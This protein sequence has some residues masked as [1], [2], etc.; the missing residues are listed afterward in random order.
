[1][2]MKSIYPFINELLDQKESFV[3]VTILKKYG[4]ASS[5]E[6][7]K[8]LVRKDF[9]IGGTIG[10]G[11]LEAM[12]IKLASKVFKNKEFII[13][14]F[15][16]S[17]NEAS[18]LG[19]ACGGDI[20]ALLEYVNCSDE[21]VIY[22]Y[23]K[24]M[25]L[26]FSNTDFIL[27]TKIAEGQK[28]ITGIDKWICTE[29]GLYGVEDEEVLD[30]VR[31]IRE[32]FHKIKIQ[33]VLIEKDKYLIEPFLNFESAYIFGAGHIAQKIAVLTKMLGFFTVVIDDREEVTNRE[34][35]DFADEVKAISTF[36]NLVENIKINNNSYVIIVTRGHAYD[37][38]VLAY[39]LRTDAKYIGMIGSRNKRDYIFNS[40]LS[41]GFTLSDL[42]RVYCPIEIR[43]FAVTPE[44]IAVSIAAELVKVKRGPQNEEG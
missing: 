25:E 22:L 20:K 8:M 28:E 32:N 36:D 10:G 4:S 23:K 7:A 33:E 39:M 13:E 24:A 34:R 40:L 1:M 37:K 18:S 31:K 2:K 12:T 27:I 30:V 41:E 21:N 35:F 26:N 15:Q 19:M 38:E 6:G 42:E 9:S 16:L 43:I 5:E 44:E 29:T 17:S 11:L 3:L 14:N